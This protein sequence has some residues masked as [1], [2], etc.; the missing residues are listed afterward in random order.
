MLVAM[1][2]YLHLD[3]E[4]Q[5]KV[6]R[7]TAILEEDYPQVNHFIVTGPWPD[8]LKED[9]VRTFDTWHYTD[10]PYNPDNLRLAPSP[11]INIVW[12]IRQMQSVLRSSKAADVEKARHLAFLVHFVGDLHQ[13]MHSTT[14]YT[15]QDPDGNRGGNEFKLKGKWNN[16]HA[17]WDDACGLT[18]AYGDIRPYGKEKKPLTSSHIERIESFAKELMQLYPKESLPIYTELD[19]N[20]W[21][22]ESHDLAIE[23]GYKAPIGTNRDGEPQFL[24]PNQT[25]PK[26]YLERSRTIAEQR[27]ALAG[28]RLA[29]VLHSIFED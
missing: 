27:L 14:M 19:P 5:A 7:L 23:Y 20:A 13:P 9:G 16:L 6:D 26:G 8:D 1:I 28:Y 17:L 15:R 3:A 11:E 10:I 12:A 25:P 2:A 18:S 29:E 22:Q 4:V 24:L 21:A